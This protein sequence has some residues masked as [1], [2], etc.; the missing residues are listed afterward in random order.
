MHCSV[1]PSL[2]WRSF[3]VPGCTL[4]AGA[5]GPHMA[6]VELVNKTD[7]DCFSIDFFYGSTK[8][9][10]MQIQAKIVTDRKGKVMFSQV[11]IIWAG[12]EKG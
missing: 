2:P 3:P 6:V 7:N 1:F 12:E 5:P 8:F 4:S 11:S 9:T 10:C